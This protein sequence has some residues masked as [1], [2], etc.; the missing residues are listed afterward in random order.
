MHAHRAAGSSPG[1][2]SESQRLSREP[3]EGGGGESGGVEVEGEG[4]GE[5]EGGE[6]E[7]AGTE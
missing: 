2:Q 6:G 7:R 5:G 4:G 3:C 1:G